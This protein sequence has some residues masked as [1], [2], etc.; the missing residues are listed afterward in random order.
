MPE[1][2]PLEAPDR[3]EEALLWEIIKYAARIR[4]GNLDSVRENADA[5]GQAITAW[6]ARRKDLGRP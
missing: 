1:D 5:L 3:S 2:C 4:P 6:Q